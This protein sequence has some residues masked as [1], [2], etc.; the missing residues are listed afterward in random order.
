VSDHTGVDCR[1]AAGLFFDRGGDW[2]KVGEYRSAAASL[3]LSNNDSWARSGVEPPPAVASEKVS[4]AFLN[5]IVRYQDPLGRKEGSKV[6]RKAQRVEHMSKLKHLRR[7][8]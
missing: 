2:R 5:G 4:R 1:S 8:A 6:G 3:L 7:Y